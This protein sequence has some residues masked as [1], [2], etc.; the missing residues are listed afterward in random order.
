[1]FLA[2]LLAAMLPATAA[3]PPRDTQPLLTLDQHDFV[4][5]RLSPDGTRL[6]VARTHQRPDGTETT[7][8]LLVD[9]ASGAVR[10]LISRSEAEANETYETFVTG[11][12]WFDE[13]TVHVS[14]SDGDVG[15][16]EIVVDVSSGRIVRTTYDE[17]GELL[18]SE[19]KDLA[20]DARHYASFFTQDE[21]E[22]S[23]GSSAMRLPSGRVLVQKSGRWSEPKPLFLLVPDT[24]HAARIGTVPANQRLWSTVEDGEG[25]LFLVA[26]DDAGSVSAYR[27]GARTRL[28]AW[29]AP[30]AKDCPR[31]EF[32]SKRVLVFSRP[33][34]RSGPARGRLWEMT[35]GGA[36]EHRL[37][38]HLDEFSASADGSRIAIGAWR[39]G[40]RIV[41][42]YETGSLLRRAG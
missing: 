28:G 41:R 24:R 4:F 32:V 18:P 16:T 26:G 5:P 31:L 42:V 8:V 1:M 33:C 22:Q 9:V 23:L 2:L 14:L 3:A 27:R 12:A 34:T 21:L 17:G 13:R 6:V 37:D 19:F 10:E 20:A 36:V 39:N 15:S 30:M 35:R 11:L 40:R 38:D 25:V 29:R 7:D